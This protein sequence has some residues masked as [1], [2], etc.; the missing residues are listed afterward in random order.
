MNFSIFFVH[1]LFRIGICVLV[2]GVQSTNQF[3]QNDIERYR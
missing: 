2:L 3:T 1:C